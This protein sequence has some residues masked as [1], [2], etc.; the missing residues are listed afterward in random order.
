M[1]HIRFDK[2]KNKLLKETRDIG[3]EDVLLCITEGKVIDDLDHPDQEKYKGQKLLVIE[4]K[5][6]VHIV[7]YV[8][9][10]DEIFLKTIIPSRKLNKKYKG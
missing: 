5:G 1:K 3:F 6:Y 10:D 4:I 2:E 7:L 8:E 9:T